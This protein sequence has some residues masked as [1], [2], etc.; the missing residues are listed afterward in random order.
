MA[1]SIIFRSGDSRYDQATLFRAGLKSV[2]IEG[3]SAVWEKR[4][5]AF[6]SDLALHREMVHNSVAPL[7]AI[8]L[9]YVRTPMVRERPSHNSSQSN[10]TAAALAH[11]DNV[12]R[13]LQQLGQDSDE[14]R[15]VEKGAVSSALSV[16]AELR[17][18]DIAPPELSW[19]GGDA[20]VM[21]WA[22]GDTTCAITVTDGEVGYVVRRNR[23]AIKMADSFALT[24]FKL[25]D[26]R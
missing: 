24:T 6:S 11:Y 4:A 13:S 8:P 21:L 26:L 15:R 9:V 12:E 16:V 23:R 7:D 17:R 25:E 2:N 1:D 14:E 5:R 18:N 19:H 22:L 10:I 3:S 20:V